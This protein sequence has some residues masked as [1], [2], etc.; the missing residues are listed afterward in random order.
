M[1]TG[2]TDI[3]VLTNVV[4]TVW[5]ILHVTNRRGTVTRD[6][7]WDIQAITVAKVNTLTE[8]YKYTQ[9]YY[10]FKN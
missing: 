8:R 1:L 5:M 3:T 9:F 7:T 4:V 10:F 6:V 2:P